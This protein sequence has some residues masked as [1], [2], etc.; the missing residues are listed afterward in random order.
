MT[1]DQREYVEANKLWPHVGADQL[2]HCSYIGAKHSTK[3]RCLY[4]AEHTHQDLKKHLCAYRGGRLRNV[5]AQGTWLDL[6]TF[7][8]EHSSVAQDLCCSVQSCEH[9]S[10]A[11]EKRRMRTQPSYRRTFRGSEMRCKQR[12]R[13][14]ARC[15]QTA[16]ALSHLQPCLCT[17]VKVSLARPSSGPSSAV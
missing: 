5:A 10:G 3:L 12:G 11:Q 9:P 8:A 4:R 15:A 16:L 14:P 7:R 6:L 2:N 17:Q 1:E 13:P